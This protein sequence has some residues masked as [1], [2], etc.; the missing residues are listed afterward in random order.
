MSFLR[1]TWHVAAWDDELKIGGMLHRTLLNEPVLLLRDNSGKVHALRDRCPHR[2]APLHLGSFDGNAVQCRYHGLKFNGSGT[3]VH[4]P[5]G[6]IPKAAKVQTYPLVELHSMLWIWMGDAA[7]A[8]VSLIPDFSFQNPEHAFVGKDYL[9]V[10]S[11]YLL[12]IDNIMDLSHIEF[13]HPTTLGSSGVSKGR[14]EAA[15]EGDTVWSKRLTDAEIMTDDLCDAM[16]VPRGAPVDRW[17]NVRW[18]APANMALFAGAVASGRPHSEGRETPTTHCFTPE[19]ETTTHYWFSISFPKSL[20]EVGAHLAQE[21]IKFL[22]PP[23]ELEDLPMLEA[24]QNSMGAAE[25]WSLKPI[26]LAGDAAGVRV[27]RTLTKLIAQEQSGIA[28]LS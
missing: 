2:F 4:N 3:C 8:D 7:K 19:T 27:R 12:E 20:G 21:Q 11:S 18:T 14:F 6:E 1:N 24:Q 15:Q 17:I 13:L 9:S 26:L 23:F 28:E 22:R 5:H 16:G 10:R 25:F